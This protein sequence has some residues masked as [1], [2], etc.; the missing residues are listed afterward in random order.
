MGST[1][2]MVIVG[3][4]V[5]AALI[6]AGIAGWRAVRQQ[7]TC[8]SCGSSGECPIAK[9]PDA[10]AELSKKGQL[11]HLDSCQPGTFSCQ[12]LAE[13]LEKDAAGKSAD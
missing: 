6:W 4:V 1:L 7:G 11:P 12:D 8:S 10:L 3:V 5:G 9:D 13:S 2:E